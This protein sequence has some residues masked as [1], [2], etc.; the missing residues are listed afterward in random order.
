MQ[1][2]PTMLRRMK[3]WKIA[4]L[5]LDLGA[6]LYLGGK[7]TADVRAP[8]AFEAPLPRTAHAPERAAGDL[9]LARA[10]SPPRP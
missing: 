3:S 7:V 8:A 5:C 2:A 4:L 10:D 1:R 9:E 6:G